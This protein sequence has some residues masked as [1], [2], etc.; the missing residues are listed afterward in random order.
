MC[1]CCGP[2]NPPWR[3]KAREESRGEGRRKRDRAG[4]FSMCPAHAEPW[5]SAALKDQLETDLRKQ[6]RRM[7]EWILGS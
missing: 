1:Q 7:K 4:R 5:V 3:Q 2:G 6:I